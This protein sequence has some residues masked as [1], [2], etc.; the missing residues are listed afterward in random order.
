MTE[1]E[2]EDYL[3]NIG[4]DLRNSDALL[5]EIVSPILQMM[6]QRAPY[7]TGKLQSSIGAFVNNGT[8]KFNMLYYGAYQNYGVGGSESSPTNLKEVPKFGIDQQPS[9][10]SFYRF[11]NRRYGLPAQEFF[12]IEQMTDYIVSEYENIITEE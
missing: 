8:I 1:R 5:L 7:A 4:Q 2:F 9:N 10:G 11:R 12:N 3:D 6:K